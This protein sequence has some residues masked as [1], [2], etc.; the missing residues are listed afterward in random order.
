MNSGLFV[1]PVRQGHIT[2]AEARQ[3]EDADS[4]IRGEHANGRVVY[5][6]VEISITV[7]E[8][9]R[10][11]A[12]ARADIL[13]K[14]LGGAAALPFVVGQQAEPATDATNAAVFL[15]YAPPASQI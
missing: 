14:A 10:R 4:I 8:E 3:L 2:R 7:A 15:E 6:V 5:A 13:N 12:I 9:D 1:T 11:R